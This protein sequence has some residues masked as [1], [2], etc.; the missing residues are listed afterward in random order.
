MAPATRSRDAPFSRIDLVSCRNLLIYMGGQLQE[1]VLPMFHY[2]L[3]PG[4]YLFLGISE[5]ISRH[6]DLFLPED[7]AHRIFRRRLHGSPVPI[8]LRIQP[9]PRG[10]AQPWPA[11]PRPL[12][13]GPGGVDARRAAESLVLDRFAPAHVLID[14]EGDII[15]QSARLGK[16]LEPAAGTPSR[17]LLSMARRG[18]RPALRSALREAAATGR[19]AT[20][21]Q[22][23][24]QFEGMSQ[25]IT[26]TVSP[27]PPRAEDE[28]QFVVVFTDLGTPVPARDDGTAAEQGAPDAT[29]VQLE[30][31]LRET[32][33]RLQSTIEEY[34]TTAEELKSANEEM[35]SVNEELQSIN[36]ELETSKEELQSVNEELRTANLELSGKNDALDR[37]NADLRNLFAS[38]QVATI[39]LDRHLVIRGFTPAVAAIF[40]LV[41]TD[42]GRPLS[43]F[44]TR[45]DRVD[46]RQEA[47]TV[48]DGRQVVERRVTAQDGSVHFLMRVMPYQIESGAVDGVVVTFFDVTKVVEGEVLETLVDELNHRVRNMLQV[49]QAVATHTL[50]NAPSLEAFGQ[51]FLG[52]LKA[53]ARAHELVSHG[54]W[55]TVSLR[56]LLEKEL[57]PYS[58]AGAN[59]LATEGPPVLLRP[60]A[61]LALGMVLHELATNAAKHGALSVERGRVRVSWSFAG[62]GAAARLLLRWVEA[63]GPPVREPRQRTGFGSKLIQ[64]Q[65]RHDLGGSIRTDYRETGLEAEL[66]LPASLLAAGESATAPAQPPA[67]RG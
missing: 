47:S 35:I 62:D 33:E 59:R 11:S 54:N 67:G 51:S 45:L 25:R 2:A 32:R 5:T 52:R 13:G 30:Y 41:A 36:E 64:Q 24:V 21:P 7:R 8:P 17:H 18:L 12:R 48:L 10:L 61:A 31:E 46:L 56:E 49:V 38:T 60:K 3:R 20:R 29:I 42:V 53:L 39:F 9:V 58:A 63:G 1:Q 28:R 19:D 22:I 55:K 66:T 16:Y 23:E 14:R 34:E 15:H 26:L 44:A 6:G 43:A 65:L 50:R 57:E 40:N 4:G 37:A 27:V